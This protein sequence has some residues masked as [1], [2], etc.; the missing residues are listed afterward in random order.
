MK[1]ILGLAAAVIGYLAVITPCN[2]QIIVW[3]AAQYITGNSDVAT[4]GTFFDAIT[5][6]APS[7]TPTNVTVN[8]VTFNALSGAG[9]VHTDLSG[10]ISITNGDGTGAYGSSF[11]TASPSSPAYSNLI[12]TGTFGENLNTVTLS[13]LTV[14]DTYQVESW[15]Y[16][17]GDSTTATTTYSGATPVSLLNDPG[18]FALGTFTATTT[19]ETYNYSTGGGHN[20]INAVSVFDEST[21]TAGVPEPTTYVLLGLGLLGLTLVRRRKSAV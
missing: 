19:S 11:T 17:T 2:A 20:F 13:N 5:F 14:G 7:G 15:S 12:N 9:S 8:G 6:Y 21:G 1:N 3:G 4:N 10:D 16:Y 18:Q